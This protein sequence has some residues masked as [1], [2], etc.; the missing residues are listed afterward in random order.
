MSFFKYFNFL[1]FLYSYEF[2]V[3]LIISSFLMKRE[4]KMLTSFINI[5]LIVVSGC[6]LNLI[7][8]SIIKSPLPI[9]TPF[10]FSDSAWA[11][12]RAKNYSKP[13][14]HT[15]YG[16]LLFTAIYLELSVFLKDKYR[17]ILL[18]FIF[19]ILTL[20]SIRIVLFG[21]HDFLDVFI[22]FLIWIPYVFVIKKLKILDR[23]KSYY[24]FI[25]FTIFVVFIAYLFNSSLLEVKILYFLAPI[26]LLR[27]S[28]FS[29]YDS[30][31][32]LIYS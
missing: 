3:F 6:A 26:A 14:G 9:E 2:V 15:T 17:K 11:I 31:I 12:V 8:K 24:F 20:S 5:L 25:F 19:L 13:S 16:I 18:F 32:K 4:R 10:G 29:F 23:S 21:F 22:A 30:K 7:I 27:E 28:I 1:K